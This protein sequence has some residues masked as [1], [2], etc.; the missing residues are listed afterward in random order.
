MK[1]RNKTSQKEEDSVDCLL[2][3]VMDLLPSWLAWSVQ[4]A[5]S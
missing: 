2:V 1:I 4:S 5:H 3:L